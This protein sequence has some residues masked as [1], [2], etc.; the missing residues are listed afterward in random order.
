MSTH[1]YGYA[2]PDTKW[3]AMKAIWDAC[4]AA[5]V[6]PPAE[7]DRFFD[8]EAPDPAGVEVKIQHREYR[9]EMQDGIEIDVAAIPPH[10]T[11]IRFVNSY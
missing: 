2:P 6:D 9:A 4:H 1:V 7:V 5:N 3:L 11:V 8:G 10:V